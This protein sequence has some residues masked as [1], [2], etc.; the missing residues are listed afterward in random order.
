MD[1]M[2]Q[3]LIPFVVLEPRGTVVPHRAPAQPTEADLE[4]RSPHS[5]FSQSVNL[6]NRR[7]DATGQRRFL[8]TH[9]TR[10]QAFDIGESESCFPSLVTQQRSPQPCPETDVDLTV[11]WTDF[12]SQITMLWAAHGRCEARYSARL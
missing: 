7:S 1:G 12:K 10:Q 11:E 3:S 8:T 9:L 6:T 2:E 5:P 4:V